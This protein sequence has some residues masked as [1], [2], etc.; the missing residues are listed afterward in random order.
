MRAA[1]EFFFVDHNGACGAILLSLYLEAQTLPGEHS[2]TMISS[3]EDWYGHAIEKEF[4]PF[5]VAT[6]VL[7]A[8][9]KRTHA[10]GAA[11]ASMGGR[12]KKSSW[13]A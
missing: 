5:D 9:R 7:A 6:T 4:V 13:A 3:I 12:A 10:S 11:R 8:P 1:E 2:K